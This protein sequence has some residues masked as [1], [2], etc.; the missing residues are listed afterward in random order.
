MTTP[1]TTTMTTFTPTI[2]STTFTTTFTGIE[3]KCKIFF[4]LLKSNKKFD[5]NL[6]SHIKNKI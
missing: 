6:L 5:F 1:M 4:H 3:I 2:T